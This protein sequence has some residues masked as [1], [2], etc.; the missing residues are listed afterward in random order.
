MAASE[1]H[2]E[3]VEYLI[4]RNITA[5]LKDRWGGSAIEDAK[6][7]NHRNIVKILEEYLSEKLKLENKWQ[8]NFKLINLF[9]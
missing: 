8:I 5:N 1:G 9:E 3:V 4:N 7:S 2:K 6:R